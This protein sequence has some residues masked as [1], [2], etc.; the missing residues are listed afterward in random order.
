MLQEQ[1]KQKQLAVGGQID[2]KP[3][4]I[5]GGEMRSGEQ[6]SRQDGLD[7]AAFAPHQQYKRHGAQRGD[8]GNAGGCPA[9]SVALDQHEA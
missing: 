7:V 6:G 4:A 3:H 9:I 1:A 8:A 5:G 2:Q